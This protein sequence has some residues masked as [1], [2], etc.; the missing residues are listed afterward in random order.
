MKTTSDEPRDDRAL[1]AL[2]ELARGGVERPTTAELD[3]GLDALLARIAAN[4]ARRRGLARWSLVGATAALCA[5]VGWQLTEESRTRLP[6][7]APPALAYKIEGGSILD[8]GYLRESG[9]DGIKLSFNEGS[10]LVLM[11]G[12][13]GRL[14]A[15]DTEG[16]SV[17]IE[18]GT[19]SFQVTQ[20]PDR[21]WLVEAGPFLVT[22]KGTVFSI[23]WDP[24]SERFEL[25]LRR[26]RVVVSGPVSGGDI[27]LRAGQRLVVNLPRAETLITEENLA[28]VTR[29]EVGAPVS[30]AANPPVVRPSLMREKR[31]GPSSTAATGSKR[32]GDRR[33]ADELASGRWDRILKE[34]ER[35][36]LQATLD[37]ASS[38]DLYALA[39]AARYRRRTDVA[40]AALLAERRRFPG[41]PRALDALFLL[42]RVE[43]SYERGLTRAITWYDEY[44]TSAPKGAYA[45]EALGRKMTLT[46]ELGGS[47]AARPIAEEYLRRFPKGSYAGSA[48]A[49]SRVP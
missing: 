20:R 7:P 27:V 12:A 47:A 6:A 17:A 42:G 39:H 29:E 5:L 21:R 25:D 41:T 45:A 28:E 35:V 36:G 34:V 31:G 1:A 14:R 22:V 16:A 48:R 9:H 37:Q 40:R 15:I 38:E 44:L 13:R 26:G 10:K 19:A 3:E 8:G 24:S 49:L 2:S 30:P 46:N 18:Q 23:T 43:E 33:W 4:R 11:P 32:D